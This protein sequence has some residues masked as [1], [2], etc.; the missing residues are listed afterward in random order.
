MRKC[1]DCKRFFYICD[2][3]SVTYENHNNEIKKHPICPHCDSGHHVGVIVEKEEAEQ[4]MEK[5]N[6]ETKPVESFKEHQERAKRTLSKLGSPEK[7]MLH[8]RSGIFTEKGEIIDVFKKKLAYDKNFDIV[9]IKEEIGDAMWYVSLMMSISGFD[10]LK[11]EDLFKH[12]QKTKTVPNEVY[13][14]LDRLL[15]ISTVPKHPYIC[16][17]STIEFLSL[18]CKYFKI[19]IYECL[20]LNIEKLWKRYPKE[21]D[22]DKAINRDLDVE[23]EALSKNKN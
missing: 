10:N 1:I 4:I 21:F 5:Q 17:V 23:R 22:P 11:T 19:D 16:I 15:D 8:L 2:A 13:K 6:K 20:N 3:K 18:V 14:M 12:T 9:N 7:D